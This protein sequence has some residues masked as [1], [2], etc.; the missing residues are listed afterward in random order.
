MFYY[1]I[2][3]NSDCSLYLLCYNYHQ[4]HN[5]VYLVLADRDNCICYHNV[6]SFS[7]FLFPLPKFLVILS[8]FLYT[9]R[10]IILKDPSINVK[11]NTLSGVATDILTNATLN[12]TLQSDFDPKDKNDNPFS[13]LLTSIEAAYFWMSGNFVQKDTFDFW[14]IDVFTIIASLF[15]VIILQNMLIAFMR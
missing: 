9:Y 10:F 4:N 6:R 8:L 3:P 14:V 15:I 2:S 7:A 12:I 11:S 1:F 13:R 5:P